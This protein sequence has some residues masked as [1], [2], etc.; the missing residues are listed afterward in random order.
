M[1]SL[2]GLQRLIRASRVS[3]TGDGTTG[4]SF[5]NNVTGSGAAVSMS[6]YI[7]TASSWSNTPAG[8]PF[9]YPSAHTFSDLTINFATFGNK[10]SLI[11]N[12]TTGN[13]SV[14]YTSP[15]GT[16]T[17][18]LNSISWSGGTGTLN[19][20]INGELT[21][22]TPSTA[23]TV[24]YDGYEQ[25]FV[26]FAT[27][28][29]PPYE[30]NGFP[31]N[32][33]SNCTSDCETTYDVLFSFSA[34]AVAA[35]G[36]STN[37]LFLNYNPDRFAA[38]FNHIAYGP[39]PT[40]TDTWEILQDRRGGTV[41]IDAVQWATDSGFTNVVSNSANFTISSDDQTTATYYLRY[42]LNGATSWT[43]W[44]GNPVV[45]SDPRTDV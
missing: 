45:W 19:L 43:E 15:L 31:P 6:N 11:Q 28:V 38:G 9:S 32:I 40:V 3:D 34:T 12:K 36:T 23:V 25:P 7:M 5:L 22:G 29:G 33:C 16:S 24:W 26:P 17:A 39:G 27:T 10:A 41:T 35:S 2:R 4:E 37:T 13:W 14:S 8:P 18:T 21:P 44:S 30:C 20:T 42:K 1:S